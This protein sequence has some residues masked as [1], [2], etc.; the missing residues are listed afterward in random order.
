[1]DLMLG[2]DLNKTAFGWDITLIT[3]NA[4]NQMKQY[5]LKALVEAF[6][7]EYLKNNTIYNEDSKIVKLFIDDIEL[8][9]TQGNQISLGSLKE[10]KSTIKIDNKVY[11]IMG[12]S[13]QGNRRIYV[14]KCNRTT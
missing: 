3:P 5:P 8:L 4:S 12:E 13:L 6:D 1:M 9:R 11:S 10:N 7:D 2:D 14:F